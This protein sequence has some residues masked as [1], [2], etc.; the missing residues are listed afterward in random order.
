MFYFLFLFFSIRHFLGVRVRL[1]MPN[2]V[3][4]ELTVQKLLAFMFFIGNA[5]KVPKNGVF[6]ILGVKT[7]IFFFVNPKRHILVPKHAF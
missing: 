7:K 1:C 6:A 4:I 3:R 2:F 5:L